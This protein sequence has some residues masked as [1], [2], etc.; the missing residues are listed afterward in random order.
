LNADMAFRIARL[1]ALAAATFGLVA[2]GGG[3]N[4]ETND[5]VDAVNEVTT[6]LQS[7]IT[8]I[9]TQG[10]VSSP[11][12]AATVFEDVAQKVDG[13]ATDIE[14]ITPP[15]EVADLHDKLVQDMQTLSDDATGAADDIKA[16]G[17]A[18]VSGVAA[19][20]LSEA[21]QLGSQIDAT[22]GQINA[23]LQG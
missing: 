5:Y 21:N 22:I 12:Q 9:S 7:S 2:C 23:E 11:E 18:S 19:Q 1:A 10:G 15:D 20:F 13:A 6:T 4:T 3:D 16:G 17:A 14:R 8:E